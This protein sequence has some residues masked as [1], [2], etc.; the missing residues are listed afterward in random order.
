MVD[1]IESVYLKNRKRFL[2][3]ESVDIPSFS[4]LQGTLY[5]LK[6]PIASDTVMLTIFKTPVIRCVE[7]V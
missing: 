4:I 2:F 7:I 3:L 5:F 6:S 1:P